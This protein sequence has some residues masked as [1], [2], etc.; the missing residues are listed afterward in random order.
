M[1]KK[2]ARVLAKGKKLNLVVEGKR[3]RFIGRCKV[4]VTQ[5]QAEAFK[6]HWEVKAEALAEDVDTEVEAAEATLAGAEATL[7][8][9]TDANRKALTDAKVAAE[10]ALE[11]AKA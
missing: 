7:A 4:E 10:K 8:K 5:A 11:A 3:K 9:A 2:V 6:S 1:S